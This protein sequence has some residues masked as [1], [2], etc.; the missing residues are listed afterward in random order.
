MIHQ[1]TMNC[2]EAQALLDELVDGRLP[3]DRERRVQCHLA[4][5]EACRHEEAAIRRLLEAAAALPR[6]V[7]PPADLW[8]E[9]VPRLRVRRFAAVALGGWRGTWRGWLLQA[10]AA[11]AFM[12]LGAVLSQLLT[13]PATEPGP[14]GGGEPGAVRTADAE[15]AEFVWIE[16]EFLRAKE[17]LW[18][19]AYRGSRGL[20]PATQKVVERNLRIID[21]AI[22]DLRQ[23]LEDHPGDHQLENLL[24][25]NHRK[26]INLLQRLARGCEV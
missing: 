13:A 9:I 23:A 25:A 14:P 15:S 8:P 12:G 6:S 18:R 10:V 2:R 19:S 26:E 20:P 24:L 4:G 21:N 17:D 5:C 22:R 3:A 7:D 1:N 16:A 11:V